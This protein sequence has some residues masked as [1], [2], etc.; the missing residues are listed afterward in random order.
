M[1]RCLEE[2][3]VGGAGFAVDASL[4]HC[5]AGPC[6]SKVPR[7]MADVDKLNS[8]AQA[9]WDASAIDLQGAPR[10]VRE[11]PETLDGE[12]MNAIGTRE[13]VHAFGA[14]SPA[15]PK[16]VSHSDP[17]SQWT[18]ARKGPAVFTCSDNDLIDTDNAVVVDVEATRS[19]RQAEIGAARTMIDRVGTRH[20]LKPT[21]VTASVACVLEGHVAPGTS[22]PSPPP[23]GTSGSSQGSGRR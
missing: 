5:L 2:G 4:I 7:G 22:S 23:P 17:A 18:A 10:A 3:L 6:A 1:E 14:A 16:F 9:K 19:I 20:G 13:C 8:S 21:W 12:R 15:K 11:Y